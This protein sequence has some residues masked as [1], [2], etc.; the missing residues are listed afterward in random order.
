MFTRAYGPF[1]VF[2]SHHLHPLWW[3]IVG[4]YLVLQGLTLSMGLVVRLS[5]SSTLKPEAVSHL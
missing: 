3:H 1:R 2:G 4:P 5:S